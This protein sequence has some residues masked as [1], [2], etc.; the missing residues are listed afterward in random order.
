MTCLVQSLTLVLGPETL[1]N[2]VITSTHLRLN[3]KCRWRLSFRNSCF[4]RYYV[5]P[6]DKYVPID[7]ASSPWIY[8]SPPTPLRELEFSH[9]PYHN[10]LQSS[11]EAS[12]WSNYFLLFFPWASEICARLYLNHN[13]TSVRVPY[14]PLHVPPLP[15]HPITIYISCLSTLSEHNLGLLPRHLIYCFPWVE[16]WPST[17]PVLLV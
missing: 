16:F 15:A 4:L 1:F 7:T 13:C 9:S 14:T 5:V 11:S 17:L 12:S 10:Y 3:T 8:E 6:I 2:L